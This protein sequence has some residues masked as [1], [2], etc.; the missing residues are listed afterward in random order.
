MDGAIRVARAWRGSLVVRMKARADRLRRHAD[1]LEA[2]IEER[3]RG[4]AKENEW[5]RR[6][7]FPETREIIARLREEAE[8]AG[9]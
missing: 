7:G 8:G 6:W 9:P 4:K 3:Q 2:G 1:I 5:A